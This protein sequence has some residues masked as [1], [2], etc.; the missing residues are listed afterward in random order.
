MRILITGFVV[1][2]FWS[3]FSTWLYVDVLRQATR[4]VVTEVIIPKPT[5][6]VADSLA[7]LNAM[8]PEDLT[9]LFDFDKFKMKPDPQLETNLGEFKNWLEKYPGSVIVITG[10]TDLVGENAYN[11]D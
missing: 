8:M 10:C 7:K 5:D 2:V 1:F 9:I 6:A 11:Q 3:F 4:K